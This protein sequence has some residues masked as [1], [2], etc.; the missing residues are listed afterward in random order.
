MN[1]YIIEREIPGAGELT[2]NELDQISDKSCS[3]LREMGPE[4]EWVE[5]YV[6]DNKI[7]CVY[8][9][10]NKDLILRHAEQGGFP[11]NVISEVKNTIK[12]KS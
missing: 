4:I 10:E 8:K 7:Y 6:T 5:S 3:V 11:A 1:K 9:A 2:V 12:P